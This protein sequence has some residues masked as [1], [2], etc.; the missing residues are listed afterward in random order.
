MV[1]ALHLMQESWRQS[2]PRPLFFVVVV[3]L[4]LLMFYALLYDDLE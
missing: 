2:D 1:K 3:V 4:D